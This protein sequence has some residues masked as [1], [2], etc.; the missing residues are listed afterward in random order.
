MQTYLKRMIGRTVAAVATVLCTLSTA[1]AAVFRG[2]FDPQFG[3][4]FESG[5]TVGGSPFPYDLGWRGEVEVDVP[6]GCIPTSSGTSTIFFLPSNGCGSTPPTLLSAFVELYKVPAID[7]DPIVPVDTLVFTPSSMT[8]LGLRFNGGKLEGL[9]TW[10]SNWVEGELTNSVSR[11]FSLA[12][13]IPQVSAFLSAVGIEE[14]GS[15]YNGPLLLSSTIDIGSIEIDS[16]RD[17][18]RELIPAIRKIDVSDVEE[19][20][21]TYYAFTEV[22][23]PGSLALVALA[24]LATGWAARSRRRIRPPSRPVAGH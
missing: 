14:V 7:G 8:V 3:L 4:P 12:F 22:P 18:W 9:W 21:L 24:L 1:Q 17:I 16:I 11:Y 20:K 15:T 5:Q 13:V 6:D 2:A 10:P 19:N 23:E